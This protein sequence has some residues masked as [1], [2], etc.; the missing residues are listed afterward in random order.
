MRRVKGVTGT[1]PTKL[2]DRMICCLAHSPFS[3]F[4][5]S[6]STRLLSVDV[7]KD[8]FDFDRFIGKQK[9]IYEFFKIFIE[10]KDCR[11]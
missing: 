9:I 1:G 10:L 3:I 6:S 5:V 4:F 11:G 7:Q 2:R 8:R